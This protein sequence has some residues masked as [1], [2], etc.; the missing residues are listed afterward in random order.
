MSYIQR[1][2]RLQEILKKASCDAM[3]IDDKT[4]LYYL[5]GLDLSAGKL[6]ACT[7][8]AYLF[9]DKRYFELCEKSSP[10]PVRLIDSP[11]FEDQVASSEFGFIF[12]LAFDSETTSFKAYQQ[13]EKLAKTV[14]ETRKDTPLSLFPLDAPIKQLRTIKDEE[15]IK[16]LRDAASLGSQGYDFLCNLFKEGITE[17]EAATELEIFW[18]KHG[19][20]TIAFDPIIAFGSNSSMPHYR[21]GD[22]VLRYGDIIL[23]DIGVN[24]RHYHSDMTR[25][26]FFGKPN[27]QLLAIH[28]IVEEAQHTALKL[29]HPGTNIGALDTAARDV[30]TRYGYGPNFTHSLGHGV[31]LDIHEFPTIRNYPPMNEIALQSGMVITIEPGIYIPGLGGIRIEDTVLITDTGYENLTKRPTAPLHLD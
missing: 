6:L 29:C 3:I 2:H 28:Q 9:V 1:L 25:I 27:R 19:S 12:T 10:F 24:Y 18:K 31:G 21:A 26:A 30:I 8:G 17:K 7:K 16:Q 14:S 20:K 5:T 23:I 11:K 22:T 15:E 4:N 13:L